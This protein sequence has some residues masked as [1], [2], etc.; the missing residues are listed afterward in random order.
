[1]YPADQVVHQQADA[2]HTCSVKNG[3]WDLSVPVQQILLFNGMELGGAANPGAASGFDAGAVPP[4]AE[5][6]AGSDPTAR[7]FLKRTPKTFVL[8]KTFQTQN[9]S[10]QTASPPKFGI[11][12]FGNVA[13]MH[14]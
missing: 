1:M 9:P 14:V 8:G 4:G 6:R 7:R 11:F 5:F 10:A 2:Q 13:M 12:G 3:S